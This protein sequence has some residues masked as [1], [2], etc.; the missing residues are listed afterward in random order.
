VT[1][2]AYSLT[3]RDEGDERDREENL[4][5]NK[6]EQRIVSLNTNFPHTFFAQRPSLLSPSSL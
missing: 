1:A 6:T 4:K 2:P 5:W 3:H